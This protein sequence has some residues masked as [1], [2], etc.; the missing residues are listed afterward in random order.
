MIDVRVI[1][2]N[3]NFFIRSNFGIVCMHSRNIRT[4]SRSV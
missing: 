1:K 2:K 4:I 3:W